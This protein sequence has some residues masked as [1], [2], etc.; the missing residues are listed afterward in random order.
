MKYA[1]IN[2]R[3]FRPVLNVFA[4][5][6]R[7]VMQSP[8]SQRTLQLGIHVWDLSG[9]CLPSGS[10]CCQ[11]AQ[12]GAW[13]RHAKFLPL[14]LDVQSFNQSGLISH[15]STRVHLPASC[16]SKDGS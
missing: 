16:I 3:V 8:E 2:S 10:V 12:L 5:R 6:E 7:K 13:L 11:E 1:I 9:V 15:E 14:K 4:T